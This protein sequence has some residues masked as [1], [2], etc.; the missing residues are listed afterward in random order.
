MSRAVR[1]AR[2][3]II[4]HEDIKNEP[5]ADTLIAVL[6]CYGASRHG[7]VYVEPYLAKKSIRPHDILLCHPE[8]GVLVIE[9]KG[10]RIEDVV[11]VAAGHLFL[12][13]G[14]TSKNAFQQVQTT[15]FDVK[16]AVERAG[17]FRAATPIFS[18]A[19]ALPNIT[20][21]E[22]CAKGYDQ[23][24]DR[25]V[26]LF[27]DDLQNRHRL[28]DRVVGLVNDQLTRQHRST[29]IDEEHFDRLRGVF[30]DSAVLN[31]MRP[32][33]QTPIEV[34]RIGGMIEE[35]ENTDKNLS[36]EQQELSRLPVGGHPRVVRGVAGSGKSV[37]LA[38]VVAR[39][40]RRKVSELS[41][42]VEASFPRV[43]VVC[44]NKSLVPFLVAKIDDALGD[45]TEHAR[46]CLTA[47]HFERLLR[48]PPMPYVSFDHMSG[49]E[50]ARY[51]RQELAELARRNPKKHYETL[52][53]AVF[54]DEGQDFLPEEHQLLMDLVRT[55]AATSERPLI[56]FL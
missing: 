56:I 24:L 31:R 11:R 8:V 13:T 39:Y 10:H 36:S 12:K 18:F 22:W 17:G 55:D 50:R 54:V 7:F 15:M 6:E 2:V 37:V 52:F 51:Y 3:E 30:G 34:D 14:G 43:A 32:P 35:A 42:G 48:N 45:E 29:P 38:N 41:D 40:L 4:G 27:R 49:S 44:F 23:C 25:S 20:E 47:C 5:H 19:I 21:R 28:R 26:L 33:R 46:E 53:D 16:S 9:V 1:D